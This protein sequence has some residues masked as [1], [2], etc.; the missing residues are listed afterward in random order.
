V[1]TPLFVLAIDHRDSLRRWHRSIAGE[2]PEERALL[3][4]L[5]D[6]VVDALDLALQQGL[7]A[8]EAGLLIDTEYGHAALERA[9]GLGVRVVVPVERSGT[10]A[11]E[12]EHG[13][14][15][16]A[17]LARTDPHYAKALVRYNPDADASRNEVSRRRLCVLQRELDRS[18]R[19]W[20]LELLVPGEPDQL[21]SLGGDQRRYDDELRL[22][23]T[24][25]A[26]GELQDA[27]LRPELWKLEGQRSGAA[28]GEIAA[29]VRTGSAAAC[30]VLGRGEE[31]RAVERWLSLAAPVEGFAGFA[32]GRTIWQHP[33]EAWRRARISRSEAVQ[34][35]AT[36]YCQLV[37]L[38][39]RA[40]RGEVP[41][42]EVP[43]GRLAPSTLSPRATAQEQP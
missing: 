4:G 31:R 28:Y 20:M 11:F 8:G 30:L 43:H 2:H 21:S 23:L 37:E 17:E 29:R 7:A 41:H 36:N 16:A 13:D 12:F 5:K 10:R 3:C 42:G 19:A 9:R 26:I 14:G 35:I 25:R 27:G 1:T 6:V 38:Y 39:R 22:A 32:V 34:Q 24:L 40:S 33:L 15:F 18:G